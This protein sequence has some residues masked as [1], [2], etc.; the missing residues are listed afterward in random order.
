ML[1]CHRKVVYEIRIRAVIADGARDEQAVAE[2]C[3]A[4]TQC[5]GCTPA[6]WRTARRVDVN[7]GGP[8]QSSRSRRRRH[9]GVPYNS[10]TRDHLRTPRRTTRKTGPA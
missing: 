3:G 8:R 6:I 1:V 4:G 9:R 5:G 7:P 2:A 10:A